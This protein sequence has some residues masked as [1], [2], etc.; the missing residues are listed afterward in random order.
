MKTAICTLAKMENAY[1]EDWLRYHIELGFDKI[2]VYDNNTVDYNDLSECIPNELS[3]KVVV[4][5]WRERQFER[6]TPN[7]EVYNDWL[8]NNGDEYDWCAFIDIDEYIH[9]GKSLVA[10]LGS[11]PRVFDAVFL[12]WHIIGDDGIIEGDESVPVYERL[13]TEV[14]TTDTC[15]FKSILRCNS[16]MRAI[17]PSTFASD[18]KLLTVPYCDC[19]YNGAVMTNNYIIQM[20]TYNCWINHYA[21]KTLNEF[22]KYKMPRLNWEHF[23]TNV[24]YFFR[25]NRCTAEK[26]AYIRKF[27]DGA[28]S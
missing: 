15:L 26:E 27:M 10:L 17:T 6:H 2:F 11:V 16:N 14:D 3:D 18:D 9:L 21:T 4:V 7:V 12:N 25:Y 28:K 20:D 13:T 22:L 1:I 24:D 8:E 23:G 5:D 19:N